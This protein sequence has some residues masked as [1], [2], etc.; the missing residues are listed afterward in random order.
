MRRMARIFFISVGMVGVIAIQ[1]APA[2]EET[3]AL[4]WKGCGITRAAFM[5]ECAEA[6]KK[7]TG[8]SIKI[9]GGGATLGIRAAIAGSAELGGTC[10]P[11]LPEKFPEERGGY[12]TMVAW[13]AISFVTHPA[14]PVSNITSQ[15]AKDIL[16]GKITNWKDVGG[17]DQKIFVI[18]RSQT[19]SDKYSGVGYML[20][21]LLFNDTDIEFTAEALSFRD[22][23][24]VEENIQ[25]T[26]WSF[27]ATGISSA[28]KKNLKVLDFDGIAPTK[29]NIQSGQY[30][31]YRPLYIVTREI[32]AGEIAEFVQWLLSE[33]GQSIISGQGTVN[34]K[35]GEHLRQ[36][37]KAWESTDRI[38][39]F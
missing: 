18:Y 36:S 32:P 9:V 17:P 30:P 4:V 26:E 24:I 20:R 8:K 19:E 29:E 34:L 28:K 35:E 22:T 27:G 14:N 11:P 31:F 10:R 38:L 25:N 13:D 3:P 2:A 21:K 5:S 39:N 7:K 23:G 16:T 37:F 6:Y 12:L 15:Q 33:E 1:S